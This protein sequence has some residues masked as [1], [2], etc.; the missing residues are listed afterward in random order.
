MPRHIA[1]SA[2]RSAL[3]RACVSVVDRTAR[4]WAS[5]RRWPPEGGTV[6]V[7]ENKHL[8]LLY[9]RLG[10]IIRSLLQAA[11][12]FLVPDRLAYET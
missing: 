5:K 4:V 9:G 12:A 7:L 2:G 1:C 10:F 8:G 3:S 11:C 6:W